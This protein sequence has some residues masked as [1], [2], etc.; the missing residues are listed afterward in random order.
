[1]VQSV[2]TVIE[3]YN[4]QNLIPKIYFDLG[5]DQEGGPGGGT[6]RGDQG[7]GPEQRFFR[8]G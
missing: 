6:R 1:M 3:T 7:G 2:R 8:I 4:S 5:G